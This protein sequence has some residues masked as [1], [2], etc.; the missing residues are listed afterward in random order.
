MKRSTTIVTAV[1]AMGAGALL[2]TGIT[3]IAIAD[4]GRGDRPGASAEGF[5]KPGKGHRGMKGE[6]HAGTPVRGEHVVQDTTGAFVTYRMIQGTVT[7]VS[8]TSITVKAA[9]NASQTYTVTAQTTVS[10]KRAE[11]TIGDVSVGSTVHVIG[12]VNGSTATAER[13]HV[14]S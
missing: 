14:R 7:A 1:A 9:D 10:Q 3:G 11:A 4:Q 6:R 13:I 8:P 12:T 5:G 2:A